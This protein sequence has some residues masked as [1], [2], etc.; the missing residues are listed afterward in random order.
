MFITVSKKLIYKLVAIELT[1][2]TVIVATLINLFC[3]C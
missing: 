3:N 2:I 1:A